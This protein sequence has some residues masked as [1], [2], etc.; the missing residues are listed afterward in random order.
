[1]MSVNRIVAR[2]PI[3]MSG[4]ANCG[5]KLFDLIE[6]GPGGTHPVQVVRSWQLHVLGPTDVLRRAE[7]ARLRILLRTRLRMRRCCAPWQSAHRRSRPLGLSA[8]FQQGTVRCLQKTAYAGSARRGD[9]GHRRRVRPQH[10]ERHLGRA[11]APRA[12][13]SSSHSRPAQGVQSPQM[14]V[15]SDDKSNLRR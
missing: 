10:G 15:C 5:E 13:S 1:M 4:A 9:G 3:R 8:R 2:L 6:H 7:M 12:A 14:G 11:R